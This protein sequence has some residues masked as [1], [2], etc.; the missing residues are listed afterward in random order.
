MKGQ[1][2]LTGTTSLL[3]ATRLRSNAG[4]VSRA[5]AAVDRLDLQVQYPDRGFDLRLLV[6]ELVAN[7]I[8]H[9]GA[10]DA[11]IL[12]SVERDGTTVRVEVEDAGPRFPPAPSEPP[13]PD[14]TSGRGLYLLAALADRWGVDGR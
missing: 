10:P 14:A 7:A 8:E 13:P 4:A 9:G 12:L 1:H 11:S 3:V 2:Q 5:R 6:S